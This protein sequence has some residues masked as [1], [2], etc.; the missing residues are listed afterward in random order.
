MALPR[1]GT[2]RS[3]R[4]FGFGSK[5]NRSAYKRSRLQISQTVAEVRPTS[6]RATPW[7]EIRGAIAVNSGGWDTYSHKERIR[8]LYRLTGASR[9][10]KGWK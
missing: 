6:G 2:T 7:S 3:L 9:S 8:A 5:G 4:S 10:S 1:K